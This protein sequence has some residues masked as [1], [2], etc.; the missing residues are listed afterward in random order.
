[1]ATER[2]KRK[3]QP[4]EGKAHGHSAEPLPPDEADPAHS[5]WMEERQDM[6]EKQGEK[7]PKLT[8]EALVRAMV[9]DEKLVRETNEAF[10]RH[11]AGDDS[12]GLFVRA[13]SIKAWLDDPSRPDPLKIPPLSPEEEVDTA[14]SRRMEERQDTAGKQGRKPPKLTGDALRQ[15][16]LADEELLAGTL[17]AWNRAEAGEPAYAVSAIAIKAWLNDPSRPRPI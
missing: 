7:P 10:D 11:R 12:P 9:A 6:A 17:D 3:P 8:G 13:G 2:K 1:M 5:R 15:A 4:P 16:V 14:H